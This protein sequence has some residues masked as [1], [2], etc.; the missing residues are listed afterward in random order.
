MLRVFPHEVAMANARMLVRE[1]AVVVAVALVILGMH[2]QRSGAGC[3]NLS[4]D[5]SRIQLLKKPR[6]CQER[7][8]RAGRASA[9]RVERRAGA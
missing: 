9:S 5:R 6:Q 7:F 3:G 1:P 2:Q 8:G 4:D